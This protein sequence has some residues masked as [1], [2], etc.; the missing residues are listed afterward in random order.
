MQEESKA[1][2]DQGKCNVQLATSSILRSPQ[3]LVFP[4]TTRH[5]DP[6][7]KN[8]DVEIMT[9]FAIDTFPHYGTRSQVNVSHWHTGGSGLLP[10]R[11]NGEYRVTNL[12][13]G[14]DCLKSGT[15]I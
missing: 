15:H 1:S 10:E 5:H 13:D 12:S 7:Q 2:K 11:L 4:P 3:S 9:T 14:I 8:I 6:T